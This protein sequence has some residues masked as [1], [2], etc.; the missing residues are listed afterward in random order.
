MEKDQQKKAVILKEISFWKTN[1]LLPEHYCDF[2]TQLYTEGKSLT[3]EGEKHLAEQSILQTEKASL[4]KTFVLVLSVL[5]VIASV[6]LMFIFSQNFVWVPMI[7]SAVLLIGVA[8]YILKTAHNPTLTTTFAYATAALLLFSISVK[9]A[10]LFAPENQ[11]AIWAVLIMNCLI[12]LIVGISRKLIYFTI[13]GVL[14]I[15]VIVFYWIF[16]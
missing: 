5:L 1:S 12:W 16:V 3:E 14:G 4:G 15:L 10:G 13:S 6:A 7:I 8:S 11:I 9:L 2:L